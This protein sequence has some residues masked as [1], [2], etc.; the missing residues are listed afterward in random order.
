M[1]ATLA[2]SFTMQSWPGR[3]TVG[4]IG[5]LVTAA[6]VTLWHSQSRVYGV[7]AAAVAVI[8]YPGRPDGRT[9]PR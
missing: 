5:G 2:T 9:F 8:L 3:L 4:L 6:A 1:A 7:A